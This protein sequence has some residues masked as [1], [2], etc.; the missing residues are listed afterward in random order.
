MKKFVLMR[1]IAIALAASFLA[2]TAQAQMKFISVGDGIY[3]RFN[4]NGGGVNPTVKSDSFSPTNVPSVT[5]VLESR[6]FSGTMVPISGGPNAVRYGYE[7]RVTLNNNGAT[8]TNVVTVNSLTLNFG[9][10]DFFAFG[11]R[12]QNQVWVYNPAGP[13]DFAPAS[14]DMAGNNVVLHFNPPLTLSTATDQSTNTYLLGMMS[15]GAPQITTAII[16]GTAQDPVQ[17]T[18]PFKAEVK[19]Q[20]PSGN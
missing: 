2:T 19:A 10:P 3:S 14:A 11:L 1:N 4:P 18:I 9:A 12:G 16:S 17:G 5:C 8:N 6:S 20:T 13:P 15:P 7:Y